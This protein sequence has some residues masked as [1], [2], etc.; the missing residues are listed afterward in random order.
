MATI[1]LPYFGMIDSSSLDEYYVV[2]VDF[3]NTGIHIDLNFDGKSIDI[4]R[5]EIVKQF[6]DNLRIHDLNNRKN[7]QQ[8]FEDKNGETV[9]FY[10]ENHLEELGIDDLEELIGTGVKTAE[11][12]QLLLK[13]LH[14]VRVGLYPDSEA[15]FAIFDYSIGKELTDYLVVINTDENGNLDYMAMES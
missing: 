5:L 1:R 3:N 13:K 12:P 7:I 11:Q 10:L 2:A 8:D 9:R 14:L 6:I 4:G 15:Q